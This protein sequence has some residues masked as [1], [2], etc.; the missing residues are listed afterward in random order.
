[1]K[2]NSARL[3]DFPFIFL[4]DAFGKRGNLA[5]TTAVTREVVAIDWDIAYPRQV[6]S[7][8]EL[9]ASEKITAPNLPLS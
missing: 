4:Q 3:S 7:T 1:M 5:A 9:D 6:K 2:C 8:E